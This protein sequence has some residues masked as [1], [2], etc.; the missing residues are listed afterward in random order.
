[1]AEDADRERQ[2]LQWDVA[3]ESIGRDIVKIRLKDTPA[4]RSATF[5][6]PG[7]LICKRGTPKTG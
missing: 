6:F 7:Q 1:M 3:L 5:L 2:Q 4:D